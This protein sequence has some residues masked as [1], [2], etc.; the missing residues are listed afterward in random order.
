MLILISPAK[1]LDYKKSYMISDFSMPEY[2]KQASELITTL[3]DLSVADL[4][5]L[6]KVNPQLAQLNYER[7]R[8][9]HLPFST[10]N[11]RQAIFA[12]NGEVYNGLNVRTLSGMEV[13]FAQN[14]LRI[15]S[16]LYGILKPLDLIQP[17]RLEMGIPIETR[18]AKNLYEFWDD[19]IRKNIEKTIK[20]STEEEVIINLASAEYVKSIQRK[21]IKTRIIDFEFVEM[22]NGKFKPITIYMKKARGMMARYAIQ[23]RITHAEDLKG[24]DAEGYAYAEEFS[25]KNKW[26]FV[27]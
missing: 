8:E 24:F 10:E 11:A 7:F 18:N 20:A 13:D 9:W 19:R 21:K 22:R 23:N 25:E 27:R 16:G 4:I 3:R 1:N 17:Y 5:K 14:H 26:V 2:T 15:L 12:F 6:F